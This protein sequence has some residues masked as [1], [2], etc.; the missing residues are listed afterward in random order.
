MKNNLKINYLQIIILTQKVKINIKK[1][2]IHWKNIKNSLTQL[3]NK[4]NQKNMQN[5]IISKVFKL[6]HKQTL[7]LII[8]STW[9][10]LIFK[11]LH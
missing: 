4:I 3:L 8:K 10:K 6:K 9:M 7:I 11:I 5:K 1:V 2:M